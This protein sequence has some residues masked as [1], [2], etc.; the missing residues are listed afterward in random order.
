MNHLLFPSRWLGPPWQNLE[1]ESKELMTL[2]LRK[3]NGL[4][5]G[6]VKLIDA[7]WIWTEPHSMRLKIKLTLQKEIQS[8][9]IIQQSAI[10]EYVIR[11]QQCKMCEANFATGAWRAVVQVRQRVSHKRTFFYLEQL[12]LKHE[13]HNDCLKIMVRFF[14]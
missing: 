5:K 14:L 3:I 12:I 10:A 13:A 4:N 6:G 9:A 1:L 11:N 7:S 2:C 8:G